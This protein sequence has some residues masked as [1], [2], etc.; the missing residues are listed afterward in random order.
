MEPTREKPMRS[1]RAKA[2]LLAT[3]DENKT[4]FDT[5]GKKTI[6]NLS[7]KTTV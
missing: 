6:F 2:T 3:P 1:T 4:I 5:R 7:R